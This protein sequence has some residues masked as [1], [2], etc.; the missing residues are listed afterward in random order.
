MLTRLRCYSALNCCDSDLSIF[1]RFYI[2]PHKRRTNGQNFCHISH[3]ATPAKLSAATHSSLRECPWDN[4]CI[5]NL[6]Q[7]TMAGM[8]FMMRFWTHLMLFV[9]ANHHG[10]K[11]FVKPSFSESTANHHGRSVFHVWILITVY[12]I[13]RSKSPAGSRSFWTN[14]ASIMSC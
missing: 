9:Q 14:V 7:I 6:M 5:Y 1:T 13:V 11:V 8:F 12:A 2:A 3:L 4:I 10:T